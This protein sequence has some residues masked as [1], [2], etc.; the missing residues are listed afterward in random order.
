MDGRSTDRIE[1]ISAFSAFDTFDT[2]QKCC[3]ELW[4][5]WAHEHICWPA[6]SRQPR[7]PFFRAGLPR[8]LICV[9]TTH[10]HHIF[11]AAPHFGRWAD[12][13]LGTQVIAGLALSH[14]VELFKGGGWAKRVWRELIFVAKAPAHDQAHFRATELNGAQLCPRSTFMPPEH[15]YLIS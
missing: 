14:T 12:P 2:F 4:L 13:R 15:N 10:R 11:I 7:L 1:H 6:T 8:D 5:I 3:S 9:T